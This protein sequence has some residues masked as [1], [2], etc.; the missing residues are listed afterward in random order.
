MLFVAVLI[1][2]AGPR[3]GGKVSLINKSFLNIKLT[4]N[5]F[6]FLELGHFSSPHCCIQEDLVPLQL[7]KMHRRVQILDQYSLL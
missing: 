7:T 3:K 5:F 4:L 6:Q 2:T 1:A